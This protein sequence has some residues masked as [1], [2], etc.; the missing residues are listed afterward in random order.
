MARLL[1]AAGALT[2]PLTS[3]GSDG[4]LQIFVQDLV[5]QTCLDLSPD[6]T[7]ADVIAE[8]EREGK[9]GQL[10]WQGQAVQPTA[11]LADLGVCPESVMTLSPATAAWEDPRSADVKVEWAHADGGS[12]VSRVSHQGSRRMFVLGPEAPL[13]TAWEWEVLIASVDKQKCRN[14]YVGVTSPD[15]D[16]EVA[17]SRGLHGVTKALTRASMW[18]LVNDS[19]WTSVGTEPDGSIRRL[20]PLSRVRVRYCPTACTLSFVHTVAGEDAVVSTF[21]DVTGP[22]VLFGQVERMGSA[23]T[24]LYSGPPR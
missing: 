6:A 7:V 13:H 21:R 24:L 23:L 9:R 1:Q 17:G 18:M 10:T 12:R 19:C 8:L 20:L 5:G 16:L 11:S 22:L 3:K 4:G 2:S 15:V 14:L